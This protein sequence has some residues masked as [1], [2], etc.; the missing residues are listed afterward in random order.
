MGPSLLWGKGYWISSLPAGALVT[1]LTVLSLSTLTSDKWM[2]PD[3]AP[4][5]RQQGSAFTVLS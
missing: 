3:P 5:W 2:T 1:A 4:Y